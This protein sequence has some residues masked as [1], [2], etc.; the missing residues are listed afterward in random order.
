MLAAG[1]VQEQGMSRRCGRSGVCS[2]LVMA[3]GL[4][5]GGCAV[6]D[7]GRARAIGHA[8]GVAEIL[9][10]SPTQIT[11]V[12]VTRG[13]RIFVSSP[14]WHTEGPMVSLMEVGEGGVL[15][16]YPDAAW[17]AWTPGAA[18]AAARAGSSFVCVQSVHVDGDGWLW[19]L[20]PGSPMLAGVVPGA[21]KLVQ[22]DPRSDTVVRVIH[23]DGAAA[24]KQSYLNDVRIDTRTRTAYITDS[25]L[26]AI[27]VVDLERGA[28]R[29]VLADDPRTK[30]EATPIVCEGKPLIFAGGSNAGKPLAVHSD[31]LALSPSGDYLYWQA[32]TGRTLY[33]APTAWL[34]GTDGR[35]ERLAQLVE[36]LGTTV[37]TDGMEMDRRGVLYF[38]AIER[39]AV[40]A[41]RPDGMLVTVVADARIAWPD[42][43]AL[44]PLPGDG[45]RDELYFTTAQIHRTPWFGAAAMPAGGYYVMRTRVARD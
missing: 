42:S 43:F 27:V 41:R 13:G 17:N 5:I 25:G 36:N 12:A 7:P 38:S 37:V 40:V 33:R 15:R 21:P 28:A 29:R 32:L 22:I 44:R 30:A 11:G 24:P 14:R 45:T 35:P 18:D 31:G 16:P 34:R 19:V 4:S 20:D 6:D 23:F 10:E 8:G 9:A 3:L 39:D 2:V 1:F 26:G